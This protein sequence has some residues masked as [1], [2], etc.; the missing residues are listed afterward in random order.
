METILIAS[1]LAIITFGFSLLGAIELDSYEKINGKPHRFD[2]PLMLLVCFAPFVVF[3][4]T[5]NVI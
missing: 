1:A 3:M 2:V 5:Y 4:A